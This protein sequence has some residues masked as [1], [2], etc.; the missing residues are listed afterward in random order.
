MRKESYGKPYICNFFLHFIQLILN[1]I[2]L[3]D[4]Q[5]IKIL[6]QTTK[7]FLFTSKEFSFDAA[8]TY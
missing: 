6:F 1:N 4:I 3:G 5:E 8:Q 2:K 7:R